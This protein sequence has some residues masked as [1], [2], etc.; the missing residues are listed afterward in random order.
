MSNQYEECSFCGQTVQVS[1]TSDYYFGHRKLGDKLIC[2][3]CRE[4]IKED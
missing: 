2:R 3:E 1:A 4:K